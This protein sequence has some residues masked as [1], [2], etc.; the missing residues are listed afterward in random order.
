MQ[1]RCLCHTRATVPLKKHFIQ[2][3]PSGWSCTNVYGLIRLVLELLR[4]TRIKLGRIWFSKVTCILLNQ[5]HEW[6]FL[7]R[8]ATTQR[9]DDT[10]S[11]LRCSLGLCSPSSAQHVLGTSPTPFVFVQ[12][13]YKW[14]T[15]FTVARPILL[16]THQ[17]TVH[18]A[19][20]E[21]LGAT[22]PVARTPSS[23]DATGNY[24]QPS[25]PSRSRSW[26]GYGVSYFGCYPG[27]TCSEHSIKY[28][29][30]SLR[31]LQQ[32]LKPNVKVQ[33]TNYTSFPK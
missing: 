1:S 24:F 16:P 18:G 6:G 17:P 28:G 7:S 14:W 13:A 15:R 5:T 30:T 22:H 27:S 29:L 21:S 11:R 12:L 23:W 31:L 32:I 10:R 26:I 4:D 20:T 19:H 9:V 8:L 3:G 25:L 33:Q 2:I